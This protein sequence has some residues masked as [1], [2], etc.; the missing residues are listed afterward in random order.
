MGDPL[1]ANYCAAVPNSTGAMPCISA[2]GTPLLSSKDAATPESR[3]RDVIANFYPKKLLAMKDHVVSVNLLTRSLP[4]VTRK[5]HGY[6]RAPQGFEKPPVG[7][8]V[9]SRDEIDQWAKVVG[10]VDLEN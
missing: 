3:L 2:L 1:A 8:Q 10:L 5:M 6:F 4:D 7:G 9:P